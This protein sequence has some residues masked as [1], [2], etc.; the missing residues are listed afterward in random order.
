M[1]F[2]VVLSKVKLRNLT[3]HTEREGLITDKMNGG[4]LFLVVFSFLVFF[5][6]F[7]DSYT[8]SSGKFLSLQFE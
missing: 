6:F 7:F 4:F 3:F 5:F 8:C 2:S 1:Y